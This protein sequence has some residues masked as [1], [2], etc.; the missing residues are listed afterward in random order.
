MSGI[1]VT[2]I[3]L[4]LIQIGLVSIGGGYGAMENNTFGSLDN[5]ALAGVVLGTNRDFKPS[6]KPVFTR[7]IY[8]DCDVCRLYC[9][10][11]HGHVGS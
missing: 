5:L 9:G 3:G 8:C 4:T 2:L 7:S 10:L 1:V 6:E 11:F